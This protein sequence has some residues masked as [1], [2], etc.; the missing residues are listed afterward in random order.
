MEYIDA[1]AHI[2]PD[3]IAVKASV[4]TSEFYDIPKDC[5][6]R[7]ATLLERGKLA[8]IQ[9][10][11]VLGVAITPERVRGI[12][13]YLMR[14]VA[15]NPDRLIGFGA[16]HPD[17]PD[18][19]KEIRRIRAGGL[20]GVKLHSDM[21]REALDGNATIELFKILAEEN[22]PV[23]LHTGDPRF[24]YSNPRQLKNALRAVPELKVIA[25]HFGGWMEWDEGWRNLADMDNVWVDT[26]SS[27]YSFTPEEAAKLLRRF[28]PDRVLFATDYPMWDPVIERERFDALPLTQTERESIGRRNIEAFL[29]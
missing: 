21:Q 16:V 12:N 8:G 28:R 14:T 24:R 18:A 5:D 3:E 15:E 20:R 6:G 29:G 10:H 13:N 2:Y 7:L 22:M 4:A 27:L 1:H 9:K 11:M 26:S 19:R 25:A 23:M 17:M